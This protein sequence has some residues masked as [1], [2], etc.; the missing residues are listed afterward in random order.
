MKRNLGFTYGQLEQMKEKSAHIMKEKPSYAFFKHRSLRINEK[1]LERLQNLRA[2]HGIYM[3]KFASAA[4]D[5]AIDEYE[6]QMLC[7][8][9][10]RE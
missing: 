6:E 2:E 9:K 8:N 5:A 3:A 1:T 10:K 4:I 7:A